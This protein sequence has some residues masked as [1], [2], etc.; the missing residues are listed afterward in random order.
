MTA[1]PGDFDDGSGEELTPPLL[2]PDDRLWRH[3]SELDPLGLD[4]A[5][6]RRRWLL[7]H[8]SR[9]SVLTAG[10]VGALLASGVVAIATH[11][12]DSLAAPGKSPPDTVVP[13]TAFHSTLD[14][15]PMSASLAASISRVASAMV[16][17]AVSRDGVTTR[18]V[19]VVISSDGMLL[20]PSG[21]TAGAKS[22]LVTL[23]NG[24]VYV[25]H[26][27]GSDPDSGLSVVRINGASDLPAI[28][29]SRVP[30]S[31]RSF[32]L[33]VTTPGKHSWAIGAVRALDSTV[34]IDGHKL[35]GAI[36]TDLPAA[37]GPP[38]T[39]LLSSTGT[40]QGIVTGAQR[41]MAVIA[42]AWLATAVARDL[43]ANGTVVHGWIG[44]RCETNAGPPAGVRIVAMM[45]RAALKRAGLRTGEVIVSVDR[46]PVRTL[47]EFKSRLYGLRP[48]TRVRLRV[49]DHGALST[50]VVVLA[51]SPNT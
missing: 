24:D 41:A 26:L 38:G 4:P 45:R 44:V 28:A 15:P 7:S 11:L 9:R 31:N 17:V 49:N 16:T 23:A 40:V 27:V 37:A 47:T 51:A 30:I 50:R 14:S 8:P 33:D 39:P 2:P 20:V 43:M 10:I 48:G 6:V 32:V 1:L 34:R 25:G 5:A 35:V 22:L 12:A 18:A 42:P 29:F 13:T 21:G 19:G 3:P 36:V 46:T